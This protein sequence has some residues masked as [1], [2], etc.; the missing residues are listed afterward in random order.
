LRRV[1]GVEILNISRAGIWLYV[2]SKEYFLPYENFPWFKEATVSEIYNVK[3]L[4]RHHLRWPNLDIDLELESLD[5][6]ERYP[7][8]YTA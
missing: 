3:L 1:R 7:L 8:K 2:R 6:P 5:H 4:H